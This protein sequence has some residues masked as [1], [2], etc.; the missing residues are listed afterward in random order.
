MGL[1]IS[2]VLTLGGCGQLLTVTPQ[3]Q[4]EGFV[5][6]QIDPVPTEP[7]GLGF[8]GLDSDAPEIAQAELSE[9]QQLVASWSL[10][11]KIGS[12]FMVHIE[13]TALN[14]HRR[15]FEELGV[16]GFLILG[17]NVPRDAEE[18]REFL[19][20]L[21]TLGEP[22][23]LIAIDQEGGAV[24]RLRPDPLPG[25]IELGQGELSSTTSVT[26]ERQQLVLD[27]GANV[28]FGIVADVSP[29]EDAYIH[30]R[31]FGEDPAVVADH[32][33]AALDGRV[34]G[35]AVAV[36]HFPGH[37]VSKED[38][39]RVIARSTI[40]LGNWFDQHAP[41]FALAVDKD[42]EM[43]MLGHLV[44]PAVDDTPAS[45]SAEW[46]SLLRQQWA[47]DGI[48]VTDDLSMLEDTGDERY[49]SFPENAVAAVSAGA[50]L[51]LD[52][53]GT[54]LSNAL[55]RVEQAIDSLVTAVNSGVVPESQI[56]ESVLRIVQ[57][58]ASL[59]GVSRPLQDADAG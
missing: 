5:P 48:I 44:I 40:S 23:L 26:R 19:D 43:V 58:R 45:Q 9:A 20:G 32:V 11:Q 41:P 17:N 51:V 37:G 1:A 29:G 46:V 33:S 21:R 7:G 18:S 30:D 22:E 25:A 8:P 54:S 10:E 14:Q 57:L 6:A 53:G 59:G 38:T 3:T 28:N 42:V 24:Q 52:A 36:K 47:Y 12:M 13:G 35:V 39:H 50:D 31:S 16:S 15:A 49:Q 2:L 55:V 34:E 4:D 27:S 56:D